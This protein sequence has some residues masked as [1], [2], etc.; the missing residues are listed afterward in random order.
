MH[1]TI[2]DRSICR[3]FAAKLAV[4]LSVVL[5]AA[6]CHAGGA[7]AQ[8]KP[9]ARPAASSPAP[10]GYAAVAR[11]IAGAAEKEW[12][13][14]VG[15]RLPISSGAEA[16]AYG[17]HGTMGPNAV[18]A[19]SNG[20]WRR[21]HLWYFQGG[22]HTAYGG[23]ERYVVDLN[24]G[25]SRRL[26]AAARLK[27]RTQ[28]PVAGMPAYR[29][30][31][32]QVAHSNGRTYIWG[33]L[34]YRAKGGGPDGVWVVENPERNAARRLDIE[35]GGPVGACELSNGL[36]FARYGRKT[37]ILFDPRSEKIVFRHADNRGTA[38]GPVAV[39]LESRVWM[40]GDE[41]GAAYADVDLEARTIAPE[42]IVRP[43]HA[44]P[45]GMGSGVCA[46]IHNRSGKILL[47]N[48][49]REVV[50]FDPGTK[51]FTDFGNKASREAPDPSSTDTSAGPYTKCEIIDELDVLVGLDNQFQDAW[52][53]KIP[54]ALKSEDGPPLQSL[55]RELAALRP[56][57]TI[58]VKAGTYYDGARVAVA[59]ATIDGRRAKIA[60]AIVGGKAALVIAPNAD[61]VTIAGFEV[62]GSALG[63]NMAAIRVE[64]PNAIIRDVNFHD[65]DTHIMSSGVKGG[66]LIIEDS[67]FADAL[68][69]A[70]EP[71]QTHGFY[72]GYHDKVVARRFDLRRSGREG[73]NFKSRAW[74]SLIEDCVIAQEGAQSS[75]S[76]DFPMGGTHT[77]RGCV[78][79]QGRHGNPDIFGFG[80]EIG[81]PA[82]VRPAPSHALTVESS[83]IICDQAD[84]QLATRKQGM[85][86]PVFRNNVI[87]GV[88]L[89]TEMDGGGNIVHRTREEAGLPPYPAIPR[90]PQR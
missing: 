49:R 84:C 61:N 13:R 65:N 3:I 52:A 15:T 42:V 67:R 32:G 33:H 48:G 24:A 17:I 36:I 28:E 89:P 77:I 55:T 43:K 40:F 12:R 88:R 5:A 83:L 45:L 82:D 53:W 37:A 50:A 68:G 62:Y 73:H 81:G 75:R 23:N 35:P 51:R 66:T 70:S 27:P 86:A 6:A 54:A 46:R 58:A 85:P 10:S 56:G 4:W 87:V 25:R 7:I 29:T 74:S 19:G 78:I 11:A 71:G 80:H 22:G 8:S 38:M 76:F 9:G 90:R 1:Q 2:A 16:M 72:L 79:Q 44:L 63:E 59:N 69:S 34:A 41:L 47:W 57:A 14:I 26:F 64:A 60:E 31:A 30:Y 21:G 20:A 39:C 18:I